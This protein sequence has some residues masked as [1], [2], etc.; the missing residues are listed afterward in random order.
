VTSSLLAA[1][2]QFQAVH[3]NAEFADQVSDHDPLI[4][5]FRL[6][7]TMPVANAG[8]DVSVNHLTQVTLDGSGSRAGDG[9]ALTYRWT[10]TAG[11]AVEMIGADSAPS[12][13]AHR[14]NPSRSLSG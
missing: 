10:Q 9:S 12:P 3:V 13:S 1:D 6:L 11:V 8:A 14:P 7:P 4:A 2:A 5:S